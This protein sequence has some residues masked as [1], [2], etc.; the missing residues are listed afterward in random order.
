MSDLDFILGS[1]VKV[2]LLRVLSR[3]GTPVSARHAARLAGVSH[4][5]AKA[6]DELATVGIIE[7]REGTGQ[8][9]Y[10]FVAD[11][12]L[13]GPLTEL[14][15]VEENKLRRI[16]ELLQAAVA[17]TV[18]VGAIFGSRARG[19]AAAESDL[20]VLLIVRKKTKSQAAVDRVL[21]VAAEV[22][23][24]YGTRVSPVVVE[25]KEWQTRLES[26][27]PFARHAARDA[28]VF[29]GNGELL[30]G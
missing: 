17:G 22:S 7:K 11:H 4:W 19:D 13:A 25:L 14:F 23:K 29:A 24:R 8:N 3:L 21:D 10:R 30:R 16:R 18:E 15:S 20:D 1:L 9:L 26:G 27:D 2:R 28:V 12:Y 5:A 6:L